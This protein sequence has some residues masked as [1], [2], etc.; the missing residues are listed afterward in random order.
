MKNFLILIFLFSL[1]APADWVKLS[2][3]DTCGVTGYYDKHTCE[4]EQASECAKR[5]QGYES[6]C[7]IFNIANATVDDIEKPI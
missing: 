7:G 6:D 4:N 1:N 5:P 2:D 3:F